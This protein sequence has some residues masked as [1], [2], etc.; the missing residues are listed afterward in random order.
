MMM[1]VE[2]VS[3]SYNGRRKAPVLRDVSFSIAE[4]ELVAIVGE[5]GVG[6]SSLLRLLGGLAEPSTGTI[7]IAGLAAD[8]A[9]RRRMFAYVFQ[10]PTLLPWRSV[11][12]NV[13]LPLEIAGSVAPDRIQQALRL[14]RLEEYATFLPHQLSGGMQ[15]RVALARALVVDPKILLMD[16]PFAGVD[17][18]TRDALLMELLHLWKELRLAVVVVTHN[19]AEAVLLADRV[20]VL[21]DRPAKIVHTAT[22]PLPRPRTIE[23]RQSV[24][25]HNAIQDLRSRLSEAHVDH[26][27]K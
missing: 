24:A 17:E 22:I 10:R 6:K 7:E 8:E 23:L 21:G 26:A 18:L 5:S 15:Q 27:P 19:I 13:R 2:N 11:S 4:G 3:L 9:R 14:V 1:S 12:D 25:F 20:L 16:E